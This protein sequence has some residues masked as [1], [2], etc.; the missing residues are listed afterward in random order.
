MKGEEEADWWDR[1][2]NIRSEYEA[3]LLLV[4]LTAKATWDGFPRK[5]VVGEHVHARVRVHLSKQ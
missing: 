5:E 3:Q 1:E 2:L 4:I